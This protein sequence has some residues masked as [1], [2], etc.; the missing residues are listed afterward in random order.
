MGWRLSVLI[1]E[2]IES[3][4][5]GAAFGRDGGGPFGAVAVVT[6]CRSSLSSSSSLLDA[7][8]K[9]SL[10]RFT[11]WVPVLGAVAVAVDVDV[12]VD[13]DDDDDDDVVVVDDEDDDDDD[14]GMGGGGMVGTGGC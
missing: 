11:P 7:S 5:A 1:L 8:L 6:V 10:N 3:T 12:D 9:I 13:A 4:A 14:D 2:A